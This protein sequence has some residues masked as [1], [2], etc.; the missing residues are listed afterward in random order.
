MSI[1]STTDHHRPI[2]VFIVLPRNHAAG[3]PRTKPKVKISF[4]YSRSSSSPRANWSGKYSRKKQKSNSV[5]FNISTSSSIRGSLFTIYNSFRTELSAIKCTLHSNWPDPILWHLEVNHSCSRSTIPFCRIVC[6][7]TGDRSP[8]PQRSS[9][10]LLHR[11]MWV[12]N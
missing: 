12:R 4:G 8:P 2:S 10:S 6:D 1:Y 11:W 7:I 3:E 9:R 5:E